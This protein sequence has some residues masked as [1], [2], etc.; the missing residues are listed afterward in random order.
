MVNKMDEGRKRVL[1]IMAGITRYPECKIEE[2]FRTL[3]DGPYQEQ[4]RHPVPLRL[5]PVPRALCGALRRGPG[6]QGHSGHRAP[7]EQGGEVLNPADKKIP[8]GFSPRL[9][10]VLLCSACETGNRCRGHSVIASLA[11]TRERLCP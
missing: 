7:E 4:S 1:G 6:R 2:D 5:V 10:F 8:T 11:L 9:S 3:W